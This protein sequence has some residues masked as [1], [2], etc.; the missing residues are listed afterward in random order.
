MSPLNF[1]RSDIQAMSAYVV[2][3]AAGMVKLDAMENPYILSPDLQS[4]LGRRLGAVALNR[5]PSQRTEDLKTALEHY[6]DMPAGYALMLGN[7]SD[8]LISLLSLACQA[9]GAV[10]LAPE[11]GF[12][13]YA[14]STHLQG[15]TYVPVSLTADFELD[16]AAMSAAIAHTPPVMSG[17]VE[18]SR[19][20]SPADIESALRT[21]HDAKERFLGLSLR[22]RS[23]LLKA[24]MK[25]TQAVAADWV[26]AA[27]EAKGLSFDA[28]EAGLLHRG[29]RPLGG[30]IEDHAAHV[31]N[32]LGAGLEARLLELLE[33]GKVRRLQDQRAHAVRHAAD[34][35]EALS[36]QVGHAVDLGP[37]GGVAGGIRSPQL[38]GQRRQ[39]V[40]ATR[41]EEERR[42]RGG[43]TTGKGGSNAA[44][45]PE[46][47]NRVRCL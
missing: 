25:T 45:C 30:A 34:A 1:I 28:P 29:V 16:E 39:G 2:Q 41:R 18:S 3:P 33:L 32:D 43:K 15:L 36:R 11:P 19:P 12:V 38:S 44:G 24:C 31:G 10:A 7:G 46:N 40:L 8:E 17:G 42:A 26:R 9:P 22:E 20:S 27:C 47:E 35:A 5:Y 37:V 6:I 13:M 21:L 14:L 4:A 23:L